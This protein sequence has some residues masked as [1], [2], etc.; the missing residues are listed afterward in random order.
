MLTSKLIRLSCEDHATLPCR[1]LGCSSFTLVQ[2]AKV[3][4][5]HRGGGRVVDLSPDVLLV[6]WFEDYAA[7]LLSLVL[8]LHDVAESLVAQVMDSLW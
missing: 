5:L 2:L 1:T 8:G 3:T 6:G 4:S 7:T